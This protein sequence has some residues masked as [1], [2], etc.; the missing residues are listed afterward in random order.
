MCVI[1][2][3]VKAPRVETDEENHSGTVPG[4]AQD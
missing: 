1:P 3:K 2:A 4:A